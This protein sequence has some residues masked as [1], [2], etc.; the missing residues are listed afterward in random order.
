MAR[1]MDEYYY[2]RYST[3]SHA[4]QKVLIR[5]LE[6][7]LYPETKHPPPLRNM[8]EIAEKELCRLVE[9]VEKR[10]E[11]WEALTGLDA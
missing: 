7:W 8:R 10:R 11:G 9:V 3:R 2:P 6:M 5:L 4:S 1:A